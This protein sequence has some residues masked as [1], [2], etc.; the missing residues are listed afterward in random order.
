[1]VRP[2]WDNFMKQVGNMY[3][4]CTCGYM[5]ETVETIRAHWE[6]GHF[7][8]EENSVR[9]NYDAYDVVKFIAAYVQNE[10]GGKVTFSNNA[11]FD[12]NSIT[13][14]WEKYDAQLNQMLQFS[15]K[16]L[17]SELEL[18]GDPS[19]LG[20]MIV[21][22]YRNAEKKVVDTIP[23]SSAEKQKAF[24]EDHQRLEH[25]MY[26]GELMELLRYLKPDDWLTPNL[27]NNLAIGRGEEDCIGAIDFLSN[28]IE[29]FNGQEDIGPFGEEA[30]DAKHDP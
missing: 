28:Q 8:Y 9:V 25:W 4:A 14:A 11:M 27:V 23:R 22:K 17:F 30:E 5:L 7:D 26:V 3:L 6:L 19:A 13:L 1:M 21:E 16:I 20:K 29:F 12:D 18:I 15:H 24:E 2:N 10:L